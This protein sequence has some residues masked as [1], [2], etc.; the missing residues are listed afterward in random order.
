MKK[1]YFAVAFFA[2]FFLFLSNS[3][4]PAHSG[5]GGRT[6][7][8][9]EGN[10]S[11]CHSGGVY[12]SVTPQIQVFQAGTMTPVTS[13]VGGVSYDV[14]VTVNNSSGT[15]PAFGFQMT[16]L[17]STNTAAGTY[18][19]PSANAWTITVNG[20]NYIEQNNQS[21]S[22]IFT[23][24]W[25]APA[26]GA[27]AV[28]FYSWGLAVN[29]TGGTGGDNGGGGSLSLSES[30]GGSVPIVITNT[31]TNVSCFG[32]NN[33]SIN[34]SVS[35]GTA[36]FSFNWNDGNTSQ[37]RT[38]LTAGS[39]TVTVTDNT[40]QTATRTVV[41]TQPASALNSTATATNVLCFG[42]N[43]GSIMQTPSG[44]TSP[45]AFNWG[46]G[47]TTQN[48]SNL[49]AGTY[50][51][52]VSDA[53]SCTFILQRTITQPASALNSTASSTNVLCFGG[54]SGS[55][56][57]TP[58]GGTSP[59]AFNWGGGVTTQNR[60][61]LGAGTYVC[62]VSDANSC[63]FI[64]QRTIT[65]PASALNSTASST[66]VLC[67]G[68]NSGSITQTPSGGTSPYAF[69]WGGG[70]TTQNRSNL[71]AG[72]YSC[73]VSDANSCTFILQRTIT[74]PAS[75]LNSTASSTN[76][77]CFGGN[78]GS[79]TQTPSGGTSP[80][81][82]NWGGGVT[83]Q[84]RSNLVAGTYSCTV[85]DANSCT[86]ILQRTI[87]QPASALNSTAS[88][89]NVLCF[90]GNSGS[91]TQ[92]PSGG[93]SPYT[94]NWGG[95]V[96]TQ[97]RSNLVAGTYSCTVS[98]ANSCTFILQR[99][100]T[101]PAILSAQTSFTNATC[102][103]NNGTATVNSTSGG[104]RPY[105]YVWDDFLVTQDTFFTNLEARP[106]LLFVIDT[107]NCVFVD[108]IFIT[109]INGPSLSATKVNVSCFGGNNGQ[110]AVAPSG[111]IQPYTFQWNDGST[112]NPRINL[113][114]GIYTVTVTDSTGCIATKRDTIFQPNA[115]LNVV[116]SATN[117]VCGSSTG[118][119]T[120]TTSGGT[121]P[122]SYLWADGV[123]TPNRSNLTAGTYA[124]VVTDGNN[125]STQIQQSVSSP[126]SPVATATA[127]N[128]SCFGG[129]NGSI[130]VLASG[131]T[132]Q[133]SILWNDLTTVFV[134]NNLS[135]GS[136][137]YTITDANG[138]KY[139]QS[140]AVTQPNST[141]V[142][143]ELVTNV[144]CFGGNNG[145]IELNISGGTPPYATGGVNFPQ[146]NLSAGNYSFTVT[147]ANG[148]SAVKTIT[149]TQPPLL[150]A[151]E[152]VTNVSCFGGNNGKI[153]LNI[154]GGTPPYATGGVNF[155]QNNLSAG[156]YSF[157]VTD[158]NG[159]SAVKTIT[160]TQPPLLVAAEL[161]T[162]VSC[163]GGNNGK[164]ELNI[165]G[166]TPPYATGGVNFPQN[167][168]SAGNYSFTVTDAN[169]C[170][171]VKTITV[172]QPPLLVV[173]SAFTPSAG[174]N[175]TAA[176]TVVGG[177]PN[178][179]YLW[180]TGS[181]AANIGNLAAGTYLYTVTDANNCTK[182]GAVVLT[183]TA[184]QELSA[185]E[186]LEIA[187]NPS[188]GRFGVAIRFKENT[189]F[190]L[191]IS[192]IS[193]QLVHQERLEGSKFDIPIVITEIPAGLYVLKI[194]TESGQIL[195]KIV[196][197]RP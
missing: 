24:S 41:I 135:A 188:D 26:A 164:I 5:N 35:G 155:P 118:T 19:N 158:A 151:A 43:S 172:T 20:R 84:N 178:Y 71:A 50:V 94:F 107:N 156:N 63:T 131:G 149:V 116:A 89:T 171:A 100:I 153:E 117:T 13:Y 60:S 90:G 106:Y 80:Y 45:Y 25:T 39:Y 165:S 124:L 40:A 183:S 161:V 154:S 180:S 70:V 195:R 168:L 123:T 74:Q 38:N 7:A 18:S 59:Y 99:T 192:N 122:Y 78:S 16:T 97:N 189:K 3:N 82:F 30:G 120:T 9:G 119:I 157:T 23:T 145:K 47:V 140:K 115:A 92:T 65:Q 53:N 160:V 150:V 134:K 55:I 139:S 146:N 52:T 54:N 85:S 132:P 102:G 10:C 58:S 190:T 8:P 109:N 125:C 17:R 144:S 29:N 61:N 93:T 162:N 1:I 142:A 75:A 101:Q 33:G 69:N 14:R 42:G 197:T 176:L 51:C 193:G 57:Q 185:L 103:M 12:G 196:V 105:R 137:A 166:G 86:F 44:G 62:T 28:T 72:T 152:L 11:S 113:T 77:L 170:S 2:T 108:T 167:N 49:G 66:N 21:S 68:G 127:T 174:N 138:C 4:G 128:V 148:C 114:A 173:S 169:G 111:G 159:C 184:N 91:I 179:Q 112:N 147:D 46:G 129:N 79:I 126:N 133:Y 48:R 98:D 136:Y 81:T 27:G 31:S 194:Q 22:P 143:T 182:S 73:T 187:P 37:N 83:T 121:S 96:T 130:S 163:F 175:G 6:G 177:T 64:L 181:T 15:P 36:P 104:T 67:F 87:T 186:S 191:N 95:G 56:T 88:S 76:V 141:L 34:I 110:I 32:G